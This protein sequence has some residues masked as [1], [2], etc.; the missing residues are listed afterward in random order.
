MMG[1]SILLLVLGMFV[2]M[3][4]GA[5]LVDFDYTLDLS[6][7]ILILTIVLVILSTASLYVA[8]QTGFERATTQKICVNCNQQLSKEW[9]ACPY[10]GYGVE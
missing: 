9:V 6:I 8:E 10:C 4:I 1:L 5:V 3:F 2:A 7:T